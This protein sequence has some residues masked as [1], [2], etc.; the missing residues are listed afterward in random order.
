[1]TDASSRETPEGTST[2]PVPLT[3]QESPSDAPEPT[4]GTGTIMAVGCLILILVAVI[5]LAAT[6]YLPYL[7][8]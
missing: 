4:V 7:A 8:R 2:P 5:A 6:R 1:M 3:P